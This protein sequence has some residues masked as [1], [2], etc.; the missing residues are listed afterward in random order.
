VGFPRGRTLVGSTDNADTVTE[1]P[2]SVWRVDAT[3]QQDRRDEIASNLSE[4]SRIVHASRSLAEVCQA[5]VDA[6]P[7]VVPGCDHASIMVAENGRYRTI[8]A[9]DE[10]G[11]HVDALEREV[12]EGPCVDAIVS[13]IYQL[14][15]DI[16]Q[17]SQWP[18][19]L[20]RVLAE[21][22]VRG[23]AGYRLLVDGNK[24]GALN[25]FSDQAGLLTSDAAD[26]GVILASFAS[27]ALSAT[28][29]RDRADS[30]QRGLTSNRV[31]GTAVG[32]LMAAH[33]I[34]AD[35]AFQTLRTASSHLNRKLVDIAQEL[36]DR[37]PDR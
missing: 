37:G 18:R 29:Q 1:G 32:L 2:G 6:A 17:A 9:S 19:F 8:A 24:A 26:T 23:V 7:H 34:T 3:Q 33:G 4:L 5:V 27:V 31:I 12:G 20:E 16:S 36:V 10:V 21:T 13:E 25:V 15:P 35:A 11:A 22:P 30:L 28:A 14:E